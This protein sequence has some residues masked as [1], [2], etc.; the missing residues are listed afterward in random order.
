MF[1]HRGQPLLSRR[2]FAARILASLA[3]GVAIDSIAVGVGAIGY[4]WLE[5]LGWLDA[6]LDG[7]MIITGNGLSNSLHTAG[8]K[9][10]AIFDA[11]FGV[12]AFIS[13]AG[14]L[15]APIVHRLLH[16]FHLEVREDH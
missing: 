13:V 8:G 15:L 2:R 4:H 1:E 7:A 12:M 16:A 11:L 9:F 3:I 10:F 6:C 14:V 5:G